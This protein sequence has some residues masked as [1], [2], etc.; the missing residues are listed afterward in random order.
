MAA[1]RRA[2]AE[3]YTYIETDVRATSDGVV[4]V[5]HDATLDR[6]TDRSGAIASL[7]W[8]HVRRAKI[9]GVEPVSRL[10]EVFEELPNAHFNIDVKSD[11]AAEPVIRAIQQ[12]NTAHRIALASFSSRRLS[13]LRKLGGKTLAFAMGPSHVVTLAF[14]DS[15]PY[16]NDQGAYSPGDEHPFRPRSNEAG[17]CRR[18]P[19]RQLPHKHI[20]GEQL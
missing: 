12:T 18:V 11:A 4:V 5:H 2:A 10:E 19:Q 20:G 1:F 9:A 14:T 16:R 17:D 13:R 3:G 8:S 7:P 6:T 15:P